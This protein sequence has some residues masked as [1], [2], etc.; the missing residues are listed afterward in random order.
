MT[1]NMN[2][3]SDGKASALKIN[4]FEVIKKRTKLIF[5]KY[6]THKA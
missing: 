3:N 2:I 4:L 6:K 5:Y 1:L